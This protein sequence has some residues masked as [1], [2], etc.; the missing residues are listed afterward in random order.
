VSR[1]KV[2]LWAGLATILFA[3]AAHAEPGAA[4]KPAAVASAAVA[5]AAAGVVNLNDATSEEIERLP[6]VGPSKAKA[7]IEHRHSHPFKKVEEITKVKGIGRKTFV[8]LR[9]YLTLAGPT[10]LKTEAKN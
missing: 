8:K 10:T 1:L 4:N 7:I 5:P 3:L 9:P 2:A 6:G